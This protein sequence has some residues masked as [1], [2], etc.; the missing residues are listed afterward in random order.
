[1]RLISL[2]LLLLCG[3]LPQNKEE[4]NNLNIENSNDQLTSTTRPVTIDPAVPITIDNY[5]SFNIFSSSRS[6]ILRGRCSSNI[7]NLSMGNFTFSDEDCSDNTWSSN[8]LVFP[9]DGTYN[10]SLFSL[11][12]S[13]TSYN[14]QLTIYIDQVNPY[15]RPTTSFF[16]GDTFF[17]NNDRITIN[18]TCS[19]DIADI[20]LIT[21]GPFILSDSDCTDGR[22]QITDSS[23]IFVGIYNLQLT[24]RDRAGNTVIYDWKVD[25]RAHISNFAVTNVPDNSTITSPHVQLEGNCQFTGDLQL[26]VEERI[27]AQETP[28]FVTSNAC[29]GDN[30]RWVADQF[31]FPREG[32][33]IFTFT[34]TTITGL[35]FNYQHHVSYDELTPNSFALTAPVSINSVIPTNQPTLEIS[36]TCGK[37]VRTVT[38]TNSA[39]SSNHVLNSFENKCFEEQTWKVSNYRLSSATGSEIDQDIILTFI[40]ESSLEDELPTN[41]VYTFDLKKTTLA[42]IVIDTTPFVVE[43]GLN[44]LY[45]VGQAEGLF[46]GTCQGDTVF[47]SETNLWC[48]EYCFSRE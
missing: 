12:S 36:G 20:S 48:H 18:G 9:A 14:I 22:F 2:F 15:L 39:S 29:K 31:T 30:G 28:L 3:C 45:Q 5:S 41:A 43:Q 21:D 4:L 8:P 25:S 42:P 46:T 32:D 16:I 11:S 44:K 17:T 47:I 10:V 13:G 7:I 1:M 19:Q 6:V 40:I 33:Y 23:L 37:N 35:P 27:A 38:I 34:G 24:V 26:K